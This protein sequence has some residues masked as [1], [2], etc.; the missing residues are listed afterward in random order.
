[1]L[2]RRYVIVFENARWIAREDIKEIKPAPLFRKSFDIERAVKSAKMHICGLGLALS[3]VN[4]KN[5]W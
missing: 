5:V 2:I 1:M 4:G 3:Y